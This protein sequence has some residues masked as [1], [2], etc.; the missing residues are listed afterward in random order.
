MAL[1]GVDDRGLM[2]LKVI[3]T[4]LNE[5]NIRTRD[6]RRWG[7]GAVHMTRTTY[8]AQHR[9]NTRDHKMRTPKPESEHAVM[10]GADDRYRGGVRGSSAV[11]RGVQSKGDAADGGKGPRPID[12]IRDGNL[13]YNA[14]KT[15]TGILSGNGTVKL[16]RHPSGVAY[17]L[18][19]HLMAL[20][21]HPL[22]PYGS[23]N[24][25]FLKVQMMAVVRW[26]DW[27]DR[28]LEHCAFS[29]NDD[30]LIL[31]GVVAGTRH[32]LYGGHYFVRTDIAFRTR[33]VRVTYVNGPRLHIEADGEGFWHDV[34]GNRPISSLSGCIDVDI[35]I[36]PA[37]NSLPVKR[38]KLQEQASCD[39]AVA[40]VPLPNQIDGDFLPERAE[41][42]YTCIIPDQRYRYEGLFRC[43]TAELDF[44]EVGLVLDYPETFR[45][46][47]DS[48]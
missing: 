4:W 46:I 10:G 48:V 15:E 18:N 12:A 17:W 22:P 27:D 20:Y 28:G 26:R 43:F 23:L 2:G 45:R 14:L 8:V 36:T 35:G 31:E 6:G 32:G 37:T 3:A 44:D 47:I 41:Q 11:A 40:Y 16:H 7:L 19:H 38:L 5:N 33:E 9:F 1:N 29:Q 30:G 25:H 21:G 34:I 42:R 39:I 13:L 24:V